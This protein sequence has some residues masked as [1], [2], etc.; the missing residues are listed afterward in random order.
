M[1]YITLMS[2]TLLI[3]TIASGANAVA[4]VKMD[5]HRAK[6]HAPK[7]FVLTLFLLVALLVSITSPQFAGLILAA[8]CFGSG[9]VGREIY[10]G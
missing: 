6:E 10:E 4:S 3:L 1:E 8:I 5:D 9:W 7:F 2:G